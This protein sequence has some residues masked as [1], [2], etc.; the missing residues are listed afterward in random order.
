LPI[1]SVNQSIQDM[2]K[3]TYFWK[4]IAYSTDES[5]TV[6]SAGTITTLMTNPLAVESGQ[7]SDI[8]T[9]F[10]LLPNHPNPFNPE[11]TITWHLPRDA[12]VKLVVYN[13]LGQQVKI[14]ANS[15]LAAGVHTAIWDA[16]N[17]Y[18]ELVSS[19]LYFCRLVAGENVHLIKMILMQ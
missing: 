12:D 7:T 5:Q 9:E 14:I 8:P 2:P 6:T 17:E 16:T 3:G 4:V 10:A 1:H 11:T 19:G 15:N 18:G 13:S